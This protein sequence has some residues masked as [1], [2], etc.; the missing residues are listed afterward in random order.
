MPAWRVGQHGMR[1]RS[2]RAQPLP[3][4][5]TDL[6]AS[7]SSTPTAGSS[8]AASGV[9]WLPL[10]PSEGSSGAVNRL[11]MIKIGERRLITMVWR[12]LLLLPLI[13]VLSAHACCRSAAY[14][15]VSVLQTRRWLLAK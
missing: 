3:A 8:R 7:R 14:T 2:A 12:L 1:L 11:R 15:V 5:T 6:V 4:P 9:L 10:V 13:G